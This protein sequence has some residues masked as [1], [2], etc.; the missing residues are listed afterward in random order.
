MEQVQ[1]GSQRRKTIVTLL[2]QSVTPLSGATLG[3]ETGVSCQVV[4]QDIAL[5]RT[6]G[7]EIVATPRGYVLNTPKQVMRVFKTYHTN[8]QTEE[9]LTAI[10]DLGGCIADVM[11]NHRAY[12]KMSAALNIRNRR[13][14]QIFMNQLKSGKSTPLLNVTSG[15]HFHTVTAERE[16]ILDEIEEV[17]KEK[18]MLAEVLPYESELTEI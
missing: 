6:E 16:E 10:V 15:Y 12:G 7:V 17:L 1:N 18:G 3:K 2:K 5:L 13:D 9:E 14:V 4:V 11:V 8:E